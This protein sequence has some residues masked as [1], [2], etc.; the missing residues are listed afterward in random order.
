MFSARGAHVSIATGNFRSAI[1][2]VAAQ[3]AAAP[4]ISDFIASMPRAGL[5]ASPPVSN[6]IPLPT[7]A[8]FF[9]AFAP[10]GVYE[11]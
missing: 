10:F 3:T 4:D 1:A 8:Y 11:T 5:R 9:F 6:V 2:I 7:K